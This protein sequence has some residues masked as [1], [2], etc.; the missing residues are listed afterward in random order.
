[1]LIFNSGLSTAHQLTEISGRGVGMDAVRRF[2]EESGGNIKID[3][4]PA[5]SMSNGHRPFHFVIELPFELFEEKL[6]LEDEKAA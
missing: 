3:L 6:S 4:H 5:R 2:I 1:M